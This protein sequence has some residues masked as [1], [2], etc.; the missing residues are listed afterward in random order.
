MKVISTEEVKEVRG[1]GIRWVSHMTVEL[2]QDDNMA[3]I[4]KDNRE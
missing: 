2:S 1:W 3:Q 4:R